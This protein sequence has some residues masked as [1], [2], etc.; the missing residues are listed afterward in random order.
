MISSLFNSWFGLIFWGIAFFRMRHADRKTGK[1]TGLVSDAMLQAVNHFI[2]GI[3]LFYLGAGTYASVQSILDSFA[4]GEVGGVFRC[5][6]DG[7]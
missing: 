4:A 3:G 5:R 6:S 1:V 7:L 2:V